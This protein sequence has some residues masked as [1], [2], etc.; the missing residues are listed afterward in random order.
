LQKSTLEANE[1]SQHIR[2]LEFGFVKRI[3]SVNIRMCG[4]FISHL[5]IRRDE[6]LNFALSGWNAYIGGNFSVDIY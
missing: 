4:E 6:F 1:I 3:L 2:V 5:Y